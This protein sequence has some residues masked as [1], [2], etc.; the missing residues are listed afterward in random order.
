MIHTCTL[1]NNKQTKKSKPSR[2]NN[3]VD[4]FSLARGNSSNCSLSARSNSVETKLCFV[5]YVRVCFA[6]RLKKQQHLQS[7][8]VKNHSRSSKI[9]LQIIALRITDNIDVG[10]RW[11]CCYLRSFTSERRIRFDTSRMTCLEWKK[12][13]NWCR[14]SLGNIRI[15]QTRPAFR[16]VGWELALFGFVP[17]IELLLIGF[18]SQGKKILIFENVFVSFSIYFDWSF[19]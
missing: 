19:V 16:T 2:K 11:R 3:G 7:R 1:N 15:Q 12:T 8:K 10:R 13:N 6:R 17:A 4:K 14:F 5:F 18:C 9:S